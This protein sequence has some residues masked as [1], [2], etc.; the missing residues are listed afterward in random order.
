MLRRATR[1]LTRWDVLLPAGVAALGVA[2]L[3]LLHVDGWAF[4]ALLE[5]VA[6]ALL[7][8]RRL[9]ALVFATLAELVLLVIPYVGPALD[10]PAVPIMIL[11]IA[12]YALGR[13]IED[14]RGLL[15]VSLVLL[16]MLGDYLF[17]DA[18]D[19]NLS[20][21]VFV[22]ALVAPPYVLGRIVR[23]LAEQKVL[24]EER[25]ELVRREAVR[26]ERDRI[27]REMHD[28]IAHS[29]SAMVVQTAAAQDLVRTDPD[30]AERALA[31]VADTGRRAIAETG[32]LLHVLRD[33]EEELGLEPAPGLADLHGLVAAFRESGLDV[34]VDLPEEL[35]E[36]PA[37][38]DMSAYRIVQEALTN[39]LRYGSDRTA[40]LRV[41]TSPTTLSIEA[42]NPSN[43]RPTHVGDAGSGL[44]LLGMAERVQMVGG[45]LSHGVRDG[46]FELTASLPVTP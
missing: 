39:A 31:D 33:D 35:P 14:L 29:I 17:V 30:R 32:R 11:A 28:V 25:Q 46:R 34:E 8:W 41:A 9:N 1:D 18:R 10:E 45:Q 27:A 5:V 7:V 36:L 13:W 3:A 22:I 2:E 6:C 20:D 21:V 24:L 42:T 44:G 38:V 37:G 19:H 26:H 43:G 40:R 16:M 12:V 15:G 23:R 4:G